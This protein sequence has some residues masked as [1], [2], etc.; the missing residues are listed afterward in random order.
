LQLDSKHTVV[1]KT[2]PTD[3]VLLQV[4]LGAT[5][6]NPTKA[7]NNTTSDYGLRPNPTYALHVT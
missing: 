2:A 1:A 4:G 7:V 3:T 6:R 5:R